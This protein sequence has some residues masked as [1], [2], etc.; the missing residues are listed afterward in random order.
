MNQL[1]HRSTS[2]PTDRSLL[3]PRAHF[4]TGSGGTTVAPFLS[5]SSSS[6]LLSTGLVWGGDSNPYSHWYTNSVHQ[7]SFDPAK[8]AY[9]E[10]V[11]ILRK[12]L[13]TTERELI[14]LG[15]HNSIQDVKLALDKALEEY[16]KKAKGSKVRDWLAKCSS[17]VLY[18]GAVFDTFSQHHPEY[19]SLA[20]GAFKFL[21]IAVLNYEELLVEVSKAVSRIADVLPRTE[22][23]S[24]LYST[25]RMQENVAQLYA[26]ILEFSIKAI[27]FYKKG[28]LSHSIASIVKPFS[29]N[30]KPIIEEIRERSIRVDEL[31]GALSKAE[32]RDLHVK[33]HGLSQSVAQLTEMMVCELQHKKPE[34]IVFPQLLILA[35]CKTSQSYLFKR[36][37]SKCFKTRR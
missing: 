11:R 31:A 1:Q 15:E 35:Q 34:V 4:L 33:V 20:W 36:N 8:H 2:E 37:T 23:H 32:I 27:Q 9:D 6:N 21:F 7:Q 16:Q 17:R 25:P 19:V 10:A 14:R 22:L 12:E 18:Y 30:F 24:L 3:D 29:L 26:K 28:K 13:T 5:P